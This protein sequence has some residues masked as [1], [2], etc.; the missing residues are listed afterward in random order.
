MELFLSEESEVN[1]PMVPSTTDAPLITMIGQLLQGINQFWAVCRFLV[2]MGTLSSG[3]LCSNQLLKYLQWVSESMQ[4]LLNGSWQ[5]ERQKRER[6][7]I[8]TSCCL[9]E[10]F[11]RRWVVELVNQDCACFFLR[12]VTSER[13]SHQC[14]LRRL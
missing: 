14:G 10:S 2:L 12:N 3:I 9:K 6:V 7:S 1:C 8:F 5:K 4:N 11:L 13:C